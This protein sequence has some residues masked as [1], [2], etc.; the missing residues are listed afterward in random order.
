M[1]KNLPMGRLKEREYL[2]YKRR[3]L[4]HHPETGYFGR[5]SRN[6]KCLHH[7]VIECHDALA[8][9]IKAADEKL[10]GDTHV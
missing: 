3:M 5:L 8:A 7:F 2:K 6:R 4:D 1:S 10:K 9:A